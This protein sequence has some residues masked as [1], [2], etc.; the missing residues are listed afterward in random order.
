MASSA[1]EVAVLLR[2]IMIAEDTQRSKLARRRSRSPI[3]V[4]GNSELQQL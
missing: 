2:G 3:M 1:D 4:A